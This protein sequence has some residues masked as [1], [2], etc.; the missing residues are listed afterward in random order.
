MALDH[1]KP[2][3]SNTKINPDEHKPFRYVTKPGS[4]E[5][6][7]TDFIQIENGFR[8]TYHNC[9]KPDGFF[10]LQLPIVATWE[11]I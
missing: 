9:K 11:R 2:L 7:G 3:T 8:V 5:F 4:H 10:T 1:E 6:H